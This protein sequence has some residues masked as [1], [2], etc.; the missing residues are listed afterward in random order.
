MDQQLTYILFP[1][2]P[3]LPEMDR[4]SHHQMTV[5]ILHLKVLP[6]ITIAREVCHIGLRQNGL[7]Q[8]DKEYLKF[9]YEADEPQ[10][11]NYLFG[12][13]S[14][15]RV[16]V[17]SGILDRLKPQPAIQYLCPAAKDDATEAFNAYKVR[18]LFQVEN[19]L[20]SIPAVDPIK[21]GH[22]IY[23]LFKVDPLTDDRFF[24][25]GL[26]ASEELYLQYAKLL[27]YL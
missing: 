12:F 9:T 24:A 25:I 4:V 20:E 14:A 18:Y 5:D 2:S 16:I 22:T 3:F 21:A 8:Q 7:H 17:A 27:G 6:T 10:L 19:M 11:N 13:T 23:N 1:G 26:A 15:P